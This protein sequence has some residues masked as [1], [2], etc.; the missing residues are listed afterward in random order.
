MHL[1]NIPNFITFSLF[2]VKS[3]QWQ[4]NK[5]TREQVVPLLNK[6]YMRPSQKCVFPNKKFL[7]FMHKQALKRKYIAKLYYL[8]WVKN[9]SWCAENTCV[10]V[11]QECTTLYSFLMY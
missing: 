9:R 3:L 7:K 1:S 8:I 6:I 10:N 11:V 5:E 2:F 4:V